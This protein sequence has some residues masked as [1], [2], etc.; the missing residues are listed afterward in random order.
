MSV[1]SRVQNA[2]T[3]VGHVSHD[4]NHLEA[5]H[6]L[7]TLVATALDAERQDTA[8]KA[9]LELLLSESI[10]L[11]VFKAGVIDPSN[12]RMLLQPLGAGESIFA[13]ARHAEMERFEAEVQKER[14]LRSLDASEV[15]HQL[16]GSLRD[17]AFLAEGLRIS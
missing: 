13:M 11:V 16:H 7:D 17:V 2:A 1:A 8:R 15:A 9:T 14:I 4:A 5:V 12:L 6:E 3:S 10:V